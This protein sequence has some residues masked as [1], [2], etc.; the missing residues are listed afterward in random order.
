MSA[1]TFFTD[2]QIQRIT[3]AIAAA[4]KKTSGEIRVHL[5]KRCTGDPVAEA[6]KWFGKLRMHETQQV[7]PSCISH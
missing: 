3:A 4:E 2:E 1:R 6:E 7:C 5:E